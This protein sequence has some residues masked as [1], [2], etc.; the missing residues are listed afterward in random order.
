MLLCSNITK[1][2]LSM[3]GTCVTLFTDLREI[4]KKGKIFNF[5]TIPQEVLET[6]KLKSSH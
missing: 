5:K 2:K 6:I 4:L 3:D 1:I